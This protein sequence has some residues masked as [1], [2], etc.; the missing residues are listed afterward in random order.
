MCETFTMSD[1]KLVRDVMS[2]ALISVDPATTVF[3]VAKMM[4]QGIGAVLVKKDGAP[5]GIITDRD[6]AI[7]IAVNKTS[8]DTPVEKVASFPLITID[9]GD[10][11][12]SAASQMTSKK[13]RKLAVVDNGKVVGIITS[14]DLVTQMSM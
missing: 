1:D 10:T 5:A 3:Q 12:K 7:N 8:L 6:Y 13:I 14:T 9:A 11:I 4:E 2:K